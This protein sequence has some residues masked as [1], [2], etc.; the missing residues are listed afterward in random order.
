MATRYYCAGRTDPTDNPF[1][2]ESME[3]RV[4]AK[5]MVENL[6]FD[7]VL[8]RMTSVSGVVL[9]TRRAP[10]AVHVRPALPGHP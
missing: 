9:P 4:F 3:H 7:D 10:E 5:A 8:E 6:R 2:A 1:P